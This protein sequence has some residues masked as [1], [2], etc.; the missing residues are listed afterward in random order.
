MSTET[1]ERLL[2]MLIAAQNGFYGGAETLHL[3][4]LKIILKIALNT[5]KGTKVYFDDLEKVL[6][7]QSY[8]ISR[9]LKKCKIYLNLDK[10]Y[11]FTT[12]K[13]IN[14]YQLLPRGK[15][16]IEQILQRY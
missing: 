8:N 9:Y 4:E 11:S 15:F 5:E 13:K 16:F 1:I 10:E 2:N 7:M 12:G 3:P 6:G 14:A